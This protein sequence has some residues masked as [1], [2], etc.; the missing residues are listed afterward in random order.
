MGLYEILGIRDDMSAAELA[1]YLS[2]QRSNWNSRRISTKENERR[3][4]ELMVREIDVLEGAEARLEDFV[5]PA[6]VIRTL[7]A[8]MD[9]RYSDYYGLE[10]GLIRSCNLRNF[11]GEFRTVLGYLNQIGETELIEEWREVL[12]ELGAEMPRS[13]KKE[14]ASG[15]NAAS[16]GGRKKRPE[17]RSGA[18][19]G[20]TAGTVRRRETSGRPAERRASEMS[21]AGYQIRRFFR[22][23]KRKFRSIRW[24]EI[25]KKIWIILIA[26]L[27]AFVVMIVMIGRMQADRRAQA[28]QQAQEEAAAAAS[29]AAEQKAQAEKEALM[30]QMMGL[31]GFRLTTEESDFSVYSP[32]KPESC[33]ASSTLVGTTG[34]SYGT[35]Y[36]F[37]NDPETSWQEGEADDGIGV[38]LT[39]T[40]VSQTEVKG[41]AFWNGNE[42]SQERF[43]ANNRLKDIT[44]SISCK[45]QTYSK[46]YTLN[47]VMG[48]QVILFDRAVPMESV[49][50][51]IDSVYNGT[52]YQDTVLSGLA[53]LAESSG[54]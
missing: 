51:R 3:E 53:F 50:I 40:F 4:A 8:A 19:A 27:A 32:V 47:D 5:R 26:V 48:E 15:E 11:R 46:A 17:T 31:E 29:L 39:S 9:H 24:A 12:D 37:D 16:S 34:K 18:H 20:K 49:V 38:T 35:E 10:E 13:R 44:V 7:C 28:E 41:I 22:R 1:T 43:E 14:T 30:T 21:S 2:M 25:P 33:S 52:V 54:G 6:L 42:I 23:L 36:L 45:G